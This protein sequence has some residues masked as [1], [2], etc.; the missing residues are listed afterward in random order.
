MHIGVLKKPC[1]AS[2]QSSIWSTVKRSLIKHKIL[3]IICERFARN[4]NVNGD[5]FMI[6]FFSSKFLNLKKRWG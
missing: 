5:S 3:S 4:K 1:C 6:I 2:D